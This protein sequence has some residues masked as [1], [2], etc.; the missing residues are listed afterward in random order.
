M[1]IILSDLPLELLEMIANRICCSQ[2]YSSFRLT[3]RKFYWAAR[4]VKRYHT[5]GELFEVVPIKC[6]KP[7]GTSKMYFPDGTIAGIREYS[8]GIITPIE[9]LY[10]KS[11]KILFKGEYDNDGYNKGIHFW[12]NIDGSISKSQDYTETGVE[13]CIEYTNT[14]DKLLTLKKIHGEIEGNLDFYISDIPHISFKYNQGKMNGIV[15]IVS[16]FHT[17]SF[18]GNLIDDVPHG[19]Q[20]LYNEDGDIKSVIPFYNGR[21]N[22]LFR[23]YYDTGTLMSAVRY[24]NNLRQGIEKNWYETGELKATRNWVNGKK[25]G[26]CKLYSKSGVITN[27]CYFR[28]NELDGICVK[29][30]PEG[31]RESVTIYNRGKLT[32]TLIYYHHRNNEPYQINYME[33]NSKTENFVSYYLTPDKPPVIKIIKYERGNF[34]FNSNFIRIPESDN[35][36]KNVT[37]KL[38]TY[39]SSKFCKNLET[40]SEHIFIDNVYLML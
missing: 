34:T 21:K 16:L 13:K 28:D 14:G 40:I 33:N 35:T 32:Q 31:F 18:V 19:N 10:Y 2:G 7:H 26:L 24:R 20:I 15:S 38:G 22:G 3:C 25:E 9:K 6:G 1:S 36:V 29:Y 30:T 17:L 39:T 23:R 12:Y 11:Q 27:K 5:G 8:S 37:T 4:K